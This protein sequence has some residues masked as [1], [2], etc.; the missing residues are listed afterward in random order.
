LKPLYDEIVRMT[1]AFCE[2][3]LNRE[4]ADLC[5]RMAAKLA[6]K[7]PSPLTQGKANSWAGAILYVLGRVNFLFDRTQRPHLKATELCSSLGLSI[8]TASSKARL[9]EQMVGIGPFDQHWCVPGIL[10]KNPL[11]WMIRVNGLVL[12]ARDAPREI[13]EEAYRRGF[14]PFL[15]ERSAE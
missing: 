1:E 12:D 6:R 11:A 15:P 14:I 13:Q 3:N 7:R 9:I 5:T 4:Y 10:E 8:Q 2:Q